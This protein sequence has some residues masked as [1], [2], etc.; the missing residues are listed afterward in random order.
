MA[1]W[2]AHRSNNFDFVR[3]LAALSVLISHQFALH[4]M[5][6]PLV[7]EYQTLGGYAVMVFFAISGYLIT[8]SWQADPNLRRFAARRLLR[9]W[10]GLLC[11][12]ALCGLVLGPIVTQVPLHAYFTDRTT[13]HFFGTGLFKVSPFLPGVFPNS[14]LAYI[15]NGVLWTIP[16]EL[17]CY[18]YLAILG[19]LGIVRARWLM[20]ALLL[21]VSAW[22]Y[23]V[24][25]AEKVFSLTHTHL[26]EVEYATFFFSGSCLYLFREY[27]LIGVRKITGAAIVLGLGVVAYVAGHELIAAFLMTPFLVIA[28]GTESSPVLRRFGRFGD[29]SYGV[30]IYAFPV[31]QTT[32]WLTPRLG[33]YQ[34][35]AIAIP[36]TLVLAWLSWH[37]VEKVALSHK[38]RSQGPA[39]AVSPATAS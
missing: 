13:L 37:F 6:E 2:Q 8:A 28:C 22:Y 14:P 34:H 27:C 20:L 12:V 16:I 25:D 9:I 29:L 11:T 17:R 23:G 4:A 36:V 7:F 33:I 18:G 5:A 26:F 38:P 35:F 31:Q 15:P 21:G 10:P 24:H 3:L 19:L 1:D 32:I 39:A 30:Y